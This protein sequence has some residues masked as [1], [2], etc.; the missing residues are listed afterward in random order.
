MRLI[1]NANLEA[2]PHYTP[3]E[4]NTAK[5]SAQLFREEVNQLF[6][7][8][9]NMLGETENL[10]SMEVEEAPSLYQHEK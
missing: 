8:N 6:P 1:K 3:I 4:T 7:T 10:D 5:S 2:P 9:E